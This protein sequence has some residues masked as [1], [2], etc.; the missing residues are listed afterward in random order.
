MMTIQGMLAQTGYLKD[1]KFHVLPML[2]N[3]T[4]VTKNN[5][6]ATKRIDYEL[7]SFDQAISKKFINLI[8]LFCLFG[9]CNLYSIRLQY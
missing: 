9:Y 4:N 3:V 5:P 8:I 7:K 2:P 6:K 1:Q